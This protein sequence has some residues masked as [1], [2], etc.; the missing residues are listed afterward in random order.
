MGHENHFSKH[1]PLPLE[2]KNNLVAF[3]KT[4][5][6]L[7][8]IINSPLTPPGI[9]QAAQTKISS[10]LAYI[11]IATSPVEQPIHHAA[12]LHPTRDRAS[13]DVAHRM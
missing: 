9:Q 2:A 7:M 10:I 12:E 3:I 4:Y 13:S 1:E 8:E 11:P 5:T 6:E